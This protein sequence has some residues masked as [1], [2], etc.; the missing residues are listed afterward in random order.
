MAA[1]ILGFVVVEL[2]T[3]FVLMRAAMALPEHAALQ[4]AVQVRSKASHWLL[5]H[6]PFALGSR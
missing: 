6:N 3:V 4:H 2:K 1:S 5:T